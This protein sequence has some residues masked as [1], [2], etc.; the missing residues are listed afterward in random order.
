MG[1][2][3][4]CAGHNMSTV[5]NNLDLKDSAING[6]L[7]AVELT[8]SIIFKLKYNLII[9]IYNIQPTLQLVQGTPV[10]DITYQMNYKDEF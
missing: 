7:G 9:N 3:Y 1:T 10:Q 5:C 6:N 8:G 2:G 4:P